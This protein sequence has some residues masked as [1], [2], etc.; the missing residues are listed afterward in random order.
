MSTLADEIQ[1][2]YQRHQS[3]ETLRQL[4]ESHQQLVCL[5]TG[6]VPIIIEA[7]RVAEKT[8]KTP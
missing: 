5:L 6:H 8:E 3:A 4:T 2:A 7:L 1:E